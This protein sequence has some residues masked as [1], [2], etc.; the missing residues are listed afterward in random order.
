MK[1]SGLPLPKKLSGP[2]AVFS[3]RNPVA[4]VCPSSRSVYWGGGGEERGN[5][6]TLY[7]SFTADQSISTGREHTG[8]VVRSVGLTT[9]FNYLVI[10]S[11]Y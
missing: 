7:L 9:Y 4:D 10:T 2:R 11:F 1:Q 5:V 6:D 8:R 3:R